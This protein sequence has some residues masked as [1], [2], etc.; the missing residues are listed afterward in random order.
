MIEMKE[1]MRFAMSAHNGQ[2][3]GD[4]PYITHLSDVYKTLIEFQHSDPVILASAWLH[5]VLE[6]TEHHY[7]DIKKLF[8]TEVAEVVYAV[9]DELGRNR[10]E[11]KEKTWPKIKA[12]RK[13]LVVKQADMLA[14][15]RQGTFENSDILNMYKKEFPTFKTYFAGMNGDPELWSALTLLIEK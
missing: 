1:V 9:T 13:A 11:R 14:N 4:F 7:A 5:D 3:Y 8:G 10:K 6:D 15:V 12:N 2:M